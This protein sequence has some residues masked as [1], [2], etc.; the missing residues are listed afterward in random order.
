MKKKTD[1]IIDKNFSDEHR[2]YCTVTNNPFGL[3]FIMALKKNVSRVYNVKLRGRHSD[4]KSVLGSKYHP[5]KQNDIPVL[6]SE[7]ISIYLI[8]KVK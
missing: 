3:L 8:P 6:K 2:H 4:R 1:I 7:R 5:Y